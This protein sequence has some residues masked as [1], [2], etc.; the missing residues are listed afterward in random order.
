MLLVVMAACSDKKVESDNERENQKALENFN[1]SGMPIVDEPITISFMARR[2]PPTAMDY[3]KVLVW[4]EYE[5]MTGIHIDWEVISR[6]GFEEKRNLA[7]G[8]DQLPEVFYTSDMPNLDLQKYGAQGSFVN[9]IDLIDKYMPNLTELLEDNPDIKKGLTFPDGNIYSLPTIYSPEFKSVLAGHKGWVRKDWLGQLGMDIPETTEEYY[10][11]LKAVKETDLIGDGK[12]S[13]IPYGGYRTD[14]LVNWLNGAFGVGNR[15]LKHPYL[16]ADPGTGDV[17]FYPIADGYRDMLEYIHKLYDED[18]ILQN[19]F[20]IEG[21]QNYSLGSEGL[22]GSTIINNPEAQ[23]DNEGGNYV[24]MSAL[25]G[26]NGDR[27][28]TYVTSP[29]A[30]MGGF[31]VT[32]ENKNIPATL[33]WMDYFY[34]DEGAKLFFM[35][36]EGV[37]F[38]TKENGEI[39]YL[40]EIKND[41]DIT[42]DEKLAD[43]VTWRGGG[44][45]GIV[46]EEFFKGS[47]SLPSSLETTKKFEKYLPE[48]VW[49]SFTYT[50]DEANEL[51]ALAADIEKYVDEMQ[52]KFITGDESLANWDK[53]IETLNNMGLEDYMRIQEAAYE[54]YKS[55]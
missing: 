7:L 53:Y 31:I 43:Y 48:E 49:P 10:Q 51:A 9:L 33:R 55:N 14:A 8:S 24:G 18:L 4:E 45:P 42:L 54:R 32:K 16:D 3:N 38:E 28:Y 17:R 25:E 37:T 41:P 27:M 12:N 47:E 13:E 5:K 50:I 20:T 2:G 44:Y 21:D 34:S 19:I 6:D 11:F 26:P 15:G 1:E 36:K 23:F 22:Y 39:D 40:D 52:D 35:G 46:K 29:L 30:Q